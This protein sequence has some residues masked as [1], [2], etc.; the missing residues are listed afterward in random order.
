[1]TKLGLDPIARI[2]PSEATLIANR[3][4]FETKDLSRILGRFTEG[5]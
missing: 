2:M 4:S 5:T 3:T 1:V